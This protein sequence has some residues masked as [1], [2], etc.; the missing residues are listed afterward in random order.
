MPGLPGSACLCSVISANQCT[1]L[2]SVGDSVTV[3]VSLCS[4]E[5][6]RRIHASAE[7][8]R[9]FFCVQRWTVDVQAS[10]FA[11]RHRLL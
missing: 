10:K 2:G 11:D 6:Q 5:R 8:C 9:Q 3:H 1:C 4:L 7:T